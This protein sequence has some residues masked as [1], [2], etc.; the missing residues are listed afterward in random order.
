MRCVER[1][2]WKLTL[3]YVKQRAKGNLLYGSGNF[4]RGSVFTYRGGLGKEMGGSFKREGIHVYL[5][6]IHV[7]V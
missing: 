6:L 5:S 3:L 4:N 1:V 7:E 2:T